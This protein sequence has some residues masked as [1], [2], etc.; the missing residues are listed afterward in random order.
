MNNDPGDPGGAVS[1]VTAT[2]LSINCAFLRLAYEVGLGRVIAVAR[3]MGVSDSTLDAAN[4]SLVIGTEAVHPLEMAAAYATVADGGIYHAPTF[5][6]RVVDHSGNLIYNGENPGRRVFSQ[7][8]A[9]EAIVALRATVQ[10]G[11]GTAAALPNADVAGKTGTTEHSWDIWFNGITP[12]L[13]ASVW[14]GNP[15]GEV[16][17]YIDG[18]EVFGADYPTQIWHDVMAYALKDVSYSAFPA[19]DPALMPPLQYID[20]QGLARDDLISHGVIPTTTTTTTTTT[21]KP[22]AGKGKG[23]VPVLPGVRVSPPAVSPNAVPTTTS[24]PPA[25]TSTPPTALPLVRPTTAAP[26]KRTPATPATVTSART[27]APTTTRATLPPRTL[28]P[29]TRAPTTLPPTTLPPTTR[30]PTTLPPTTLA[31]ATVPTTAPQTATPTAPTT[32][33]PTVPVTSS[34]IITVPV[35]ATAPSAGSA[36]GAGGAAG[37]R[38]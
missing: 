26:T 34:P 17:V 36:L 24:T 32:V 10:Y 13:V 4:P 5:V 25:A 12:T 27:T 7:Q 11:T 35:S 29:T 31:P 15:K 9:A 6:A 21:T 14:M 30:A 16:P 19:P 18:E 37:E 38:P 1:L 33:T 28:P 23:K 22:H 3:S 20:S 2:A 8:V